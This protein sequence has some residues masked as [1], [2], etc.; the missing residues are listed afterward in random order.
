MEIILTESGNGRGQ[1]DHK[2]PEVGE[3]D[4]HENSKAAKVDGVDREGN[5][6]NELEKQS[7]ISSPRKLHIIFIT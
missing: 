2:D 6:V 5:A 7:E 4:V 3:L 1:H